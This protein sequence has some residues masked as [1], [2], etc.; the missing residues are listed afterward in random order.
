MNPESPSLQRGECQSLDK[1]L[2]DI[3]NPGLYD[4]YVAFAER[5]LQGQTGRSSDLARVGMSAAMPPQEAIAH[6]VTA[7]PPA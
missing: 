1:K 7:N 2:A 4:E 5:Y 6:F 3:D